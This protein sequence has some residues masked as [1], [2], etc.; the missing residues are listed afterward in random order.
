MGTFDEFRAAFGDMA[1]RS[2]HHI[3][4]RLDW[5]RAFRIEAYRDG[6]MTA[7][8]PV[9]KPPKTNAHSA[10]MI[11]LRSSLQSGKRC[12][13]AAIS[14]NIALSSGVLTDCANR[15]QSAAWRLYSAGLVDICPPVAG[16]LSR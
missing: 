1:I 2:V 4:A 10:P 15:R 11:V 16:Q 5:A 12:H 8:G 14:T 6:F 3:V 13:A 7:I 9:N